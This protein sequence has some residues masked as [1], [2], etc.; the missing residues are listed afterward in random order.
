MPKLNTE[1]R[2]PGCKKPTDA[3]SYKIKH[4]DYTCN[5]CWTAKRKASRRSNPDRERA[6]NRRY[7]KKRKPRRATYESNKKQIQ[8]R[9]KVQYALRTGKLTKQPCRVCGDPNSQAHHP[10]YDK[11]L[12][13]VWLCHDHHMDEHFGE[14]RNEF[15]SVPDR[16]S[17]LQRAGA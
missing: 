3:P 4:H 9:N 13:V 1:R 6:N 14:E 5:A 12:E 11:P 16:G 2:C 17:Q 15:T 10:D 7:N 8:A